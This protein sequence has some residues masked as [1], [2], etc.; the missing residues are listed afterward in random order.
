MLDFNQAPVKPL[1]LASSGVTYPL[2]SCKATASSSSAASV[3]ANLNVYDPHVG[4]NESVTLALA[5]SGDDY[6]GD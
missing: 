6:P 4:I 2:S 5:Y 3:P 1:I